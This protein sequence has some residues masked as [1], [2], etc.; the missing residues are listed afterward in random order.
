MGYGLAAANYETATTLARMGH[1]VRVLVPSVRRATSVQEG[2]TCHEFVEGDVESI[3]D[4]PYASTYRLL[5]EHAGKSYA[6]PCRFWLEYTELCRSGF[7]PDLIECQDWEQTGYFYALHRQLGYEEAT[8]PLVTMSYGSLQFSL[9]TNEDPSFV[10]ANYDRIC[11]EK[12]LMAASD[13]LAVCSQYLGDLIWAKL[14]VDK[15]EVCYNMSSTAIPENRLPPCTKK[16][17]LFFGRIS[18]GKGV[19]LLLE[20]C[21]QM[22]D[23]G[24]EFT[25]KLMGGTDWFVSIGEEVVSYI[26]RVY[27]AYI[28]RGV[29][30]LIP[31]ATT[32]AAVR[33]RLA[34][35][36]AV[37]H[38][39]LHE[40]LPYSCIEAMA[41]STYRPIDV[42]IIDNGTGEKLSNHTL[43]AI[44]RGVPDQHAFTV[45]VHRAKPRGSVTEAFNTGVSL[46]AGE[47]LSLLDCSVL[48]DRE[49]YRKAID[50][51]RQQ[52]N[53]GTALYPEGLPDLRHQ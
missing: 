44:R 18:Y 39:S 30:E 25:L 29:L 31:P 13:A 27:G 35:S 4:N 1:E 32:F 3:P 50:A 38:P 42:V 8:V 16:E 33:E 28:D 7:V 46:S 11:R 40:G 9:G 36:R 48:V 45:R 20:V 52:S 51:L 17:L 34:D 43:T 21:A 22:C 24:E 23:D 41:A 19:I 53:M 49:F 6:L 5:A 14:H 26:R 47:F 2:V 37:V 10:M 15:P 12:Y